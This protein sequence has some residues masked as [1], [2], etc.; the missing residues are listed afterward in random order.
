M[1]K[2]LLEIDETDLYKAL[3][4]CI[5]HANGDEIA[6]LITSIIGF[7]DHASTLFFKTYLGD[8]TPTVLPYGTMVRVDPKKLSFSA[9]VDKMREKGLLDNQGNCTAI[10]HKFEGFYQPTTYWVSYQNIDHKDEIVEDTG[11]IN[12]KDI[13]EVIEE[14]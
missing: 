11:F 5:D 3:R 4:S 8:V 6:K 10:I 2:I 7:S 14:F 12:F 9:R 1:T 13:L